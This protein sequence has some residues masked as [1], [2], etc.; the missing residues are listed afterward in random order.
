LP[1]RKVLLEQYL[2]PTEAGGLRADSSVLSSGFSV[3]ITGES[4]GNTM[5]DALLVLLTILFFALA[6]A[7]T[8]A[9]DRL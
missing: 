9:C 8:R 4:G 1:A 7:Y 6:A 5:F 3:F 2:P